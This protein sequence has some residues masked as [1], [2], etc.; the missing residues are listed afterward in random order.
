MTE[1]TTK[2]RARNKG[3]GLSIERVYT[4]PGVHPYD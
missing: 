2:S 3:N 1:T 4:T